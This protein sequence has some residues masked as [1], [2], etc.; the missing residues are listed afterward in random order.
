MEITQYIKSIEVEKNEKAN[1][2]V[3]SERLKK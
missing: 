1:E 2:M 3:I